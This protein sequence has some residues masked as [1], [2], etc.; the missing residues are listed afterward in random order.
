MA[1]HS[2]V[3]FFIGMITAAFG[4][5]GTALVATR[6]AS[7][8]GMVLITVAFVIFYSTWCLTTIP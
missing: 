7:G 6:T 5:V 1:V 3:A 4:G 2:M 8:V